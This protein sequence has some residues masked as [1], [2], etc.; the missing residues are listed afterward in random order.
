MQSAMDFMQG[1]GFDDTA[2]L[3]NMRQFLYN[4][5]SQAAREALARWWNL[6]QTFT[7]RDQV[8]AP[9]SLT[10]CGAKL[11]QVC[12]AIGTATSVCVMSAIRRGGAVKGSW[13]RQGQVQRSKPRH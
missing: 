6:T 3:F 1:Q 7:F 13:K 5:Q 8:T 12:R 10:C 4:A 9:H 2:G 11:W